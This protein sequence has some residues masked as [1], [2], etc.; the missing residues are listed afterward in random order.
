MPS[1]GCDPGLRPRLQ[2]IPRGGGRP[3]R[4]AGP[5]ARRRLPARADRALP[6]R[7]PLLALH[8]L[9]TVTFQATQ[10]GQP[11]V[12]RPELPG[13]HRGPTPA[14]PVPSPAGHR[15]AGLAAFRDRPGPDD[16]PPRLHRLRAGAAPGRPPPSRRVRPTERTLG[17]P[18]GQT[19]AGVG[20]GSR[21][22][23]GLSQSWAARRPRPPR[24]KHCA[25]SL[26]DA[27]RRTAANLP[28]ND[29]RPHRDRS[30]TRD[31]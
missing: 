16:R 23:P 10:A 25:A 7:P 18:S 8:V 4:D 6:P 20:L 11:V 19:L 5:A 17:R 21:P 28:A 26:D 9:R 14:R 3:G 30:R 1:S 13:R 31:A 24:W 27:Y 22:V 2:T 29:G 15:P 12:Q